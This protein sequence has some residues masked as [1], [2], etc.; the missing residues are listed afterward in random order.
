MAAGPY[1]NEGPVNGSEYAGG[2]ATCEAGGHRRG[3]ASGT[4]AGSTAA[5]GP[6][7]EHQRRAASTPEV[8]DWDPWRRKIIELNR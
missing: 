8:S 3:T 6:V 1:T 2:E 5:E 7:E 4:E